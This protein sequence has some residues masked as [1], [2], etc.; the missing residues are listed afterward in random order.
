MTKVVQCLLR[1]RNTAFRTGDG[2][3]YSAARANLMRDIREAKAVYRKRT[4]DYSRANNSRQVWQGVQHITNYRP[5]N[6]SADA[7]DTSL[8]EELNH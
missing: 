6:T 8:A 4:E 5:S 7:S 1:E 3:L 2:A